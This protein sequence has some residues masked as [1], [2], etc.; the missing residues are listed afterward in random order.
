MRRRS[1]RFGAEYSVT[2]PARYLY[3][4]KKTLSPGARGQIRWLVDKKHVGEDPQAV[5]DSIASRMKSGTPPWLITAV[6]K[7][8]IKVHERNRKL[9]RQVMRGGFGGVRCKKAIRSGRNSRAQA[10]PK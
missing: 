9:Y 4:G 1:R 7:E 2:D 10:L 8:A 6:R 3:N 5:A